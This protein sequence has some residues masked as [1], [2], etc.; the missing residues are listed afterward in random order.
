MAER[1]IKSFHID[2]EAG[3]IEVAFLDGQTLKRRIVPED[4]VQHAVEESKRDDVVKPEETPQLQT[5]AQK[6][7]TLTGRIKG[8]GKDK[9]PVVEGRP[10]GKGNPT[11]WTRLAAHFEGEE[12]AKMLSTTFHRAATRIA[13]GLSLNDQITVSGY[14]RPSQTE[15]RMDSFSVYH[16]VDW[17][18]RNPKPG[19]SGH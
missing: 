10:D 17:P 2:F 11:A 5:E 19:C 1:D 16:L 18:G 7:F 8:A 12:E 13:L 15:G 6:T 14:L 3:H 9:A 4:P